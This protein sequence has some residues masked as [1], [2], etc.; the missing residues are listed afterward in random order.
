MPNCDIVKVKNTPTAN[1]GMSRS[2]MPPNPC[3]DGKKDN[4]DREDQAAS[5]YRKGARQKVVLGNQAAHPRKIDKARIG[6]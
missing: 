1:S 4:A 3:G 6:R 5:D 2:V